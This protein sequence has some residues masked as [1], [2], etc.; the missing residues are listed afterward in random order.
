MTL[1]THELTPK[2]FFIIKMLQLK[3]YDNTDNKRSLFTI[4]LIRKAEN[5]EDDKYH[6]MDANEI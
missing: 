3:Q 4:N 6:R 2:Q 5:R 1:Q